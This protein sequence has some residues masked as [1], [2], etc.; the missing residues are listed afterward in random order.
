MLLLGFVDL[1]SNGYLLHP[2]RT[3]LHK[4]IALLVCDKPLRL[5]TYHQLFRYSV[6]YWSCENYQ[7]A[8]ADWA[9][10]SDMQQWGGKIS[11]CQRLQNQYTMF[12]ELTYICLSSKRSFHYKGK[13]LVRLQDRRRGNESSQHTNVDKE[14][15][16]QVVQQSSNQLTVREDRSG[17]IQQRASFESHSD[18]TETYR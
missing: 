18:T 6:K 2:T 3:H 14:R 12:F 17:L 5:L 1:R 11:Q 15:C 4:A 8:K 9:F 13:A 7:T 10:R 16:K